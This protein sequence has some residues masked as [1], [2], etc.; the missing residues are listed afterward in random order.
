MYLSL[1]KLKEKRMNK[2][3][4]GKILRI[5]FIFNVFNSIIKLKNGYF[6][7]ELNANIGC[8]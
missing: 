1:F 2:K 6:V 5:S 3:T 8:I 7:I 4:A